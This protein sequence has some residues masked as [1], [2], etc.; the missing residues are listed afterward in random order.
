MCSGMGRTPPAAADQAGERPAAERCRGAHVPLGMGLHA[1]SPTCPIGGSPRSGSL[2]TRYD[3]EF[4]RAAG[5]GDVHD[6][7]AAMLGGSGPVTRACS[8]M[9]RTWGRSCNSC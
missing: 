1:R 8:V 6:P 4:R 7:G 9:H 3:V 2:P 5:V